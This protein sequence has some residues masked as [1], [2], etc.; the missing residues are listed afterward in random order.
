[1]EADASD[2]SD[3]IGSRRHSCNLK[4]AIYT[5]TLAHSGMGDP[6]TQGRQALLLPGFLILHFHGRSAV[7]QSCLSERRVALFGHRSCYWCYPPLVPCDA[8]ANAQGVATCT[9]DRIHSLRQAGTHR[10]SLCTCMEDDN[11]VDGLQSPWMEVSHSLARS[12]TH[13]AANADVRDGQAPPA[14]ADVSAV[15]VAAA[16]AVGAA[17]AVGAEAEA[18]FAAAVVGSL[19]HTYP[20]LSVGWLEM[21]MGPDFRHHRHQSPTAHLGKVVVELTSCTARS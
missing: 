9:S 19:V 15:A 14:S 10:S 6:K 3:S 8:A 13:P 4:L 18:M 16:V 7:S 5:G 17:Q 21:R 1:M 20:Y 2:R 11:C 12:V